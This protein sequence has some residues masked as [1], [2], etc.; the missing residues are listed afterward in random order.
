VIR[1]EGIVVRVEKN[2][3]PYSKMKK[4]ELKCCNL[5][6]GNCPRPQVTQT[7]PLGWRSPPEEYWPTMLD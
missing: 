3:L 1:L 6:K 2:T 5:G 4:G 7:G